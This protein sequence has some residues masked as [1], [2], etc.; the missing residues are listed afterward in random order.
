MAVT[1]PVFFDPAY[2]ATTVAFDTT[3]KAALVATRLAAQP[4]PGVEMVQPRP[5]TIE[6]L[7]TVHTGDYLDAL[8]TGRPPGLAASNGI[9]WDEGLLG[10]VAASTGGVRDAALTAL[11]T[12]RHAGSLSSGLHHARADGGRGF[13]TI[14]G[15]AVAARAA[16]DAG[17]RRVLVLDLDAHAGGGTATIISSWTSV[18]QVDVTVCPFD[19]YDSRPSC[20]LVISDADAY[21]LDVHAALDGVTDPTNSDLTIYNAGMDPHHRAGGI[22][23][24]DTGRLAER[25][26]VVRSWADHHGIPVAWVLAGGYAGSGGMGKM[27]PDELVDLHLLT[28]AA[29]SPAPTACPRRAE[30]R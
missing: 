2:T 8:V 28:V 13:C 26:A 16:V 27:T 17:A 14:N 10:A 25:E 11:A 6:E 19:S 30:A 5:A 1:M 15:L 7:A 18:E 22:P 3:R 20:R 21:L 23:G 24:I 4:R 12:G 29:F 9:G